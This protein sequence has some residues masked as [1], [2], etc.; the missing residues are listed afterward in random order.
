MSGEENQV[1][2]RGFRPVSG[3]RG[4]WPSIDAVRVNQTGFQTAAGTSVLYT[5]AAGKKL[6][7]SQAQLTGRMSASAN[8]LGRLMV[9]DGAAAQKYWLVSLALT[10][11]GNLSES[12]NFMPA[13]ELDADWHV[14]MVN[15]GGELD[16][17]GA[18][19]GWLEE[20]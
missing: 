5:V 11:A 7:I 2:W 3:I 19:A 1:K 14:D 16:L 9:V 4:V 10:I 20:A 8:H 17:Y 13:I 18:F 15:S 12:C 6:F